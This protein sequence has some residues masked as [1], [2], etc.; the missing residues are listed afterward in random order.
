VTDSEKHSSLLR[1]G[2]CYCCKKILSK[3]QRF[4]IQKALLH[5]RRKLNH[6]KKLFA[7]YAKSSEASLGNSEWQNQ[8]TLTELEGSVHLTSSLS[9][10]FGKKKLKYTISKAANLN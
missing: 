9:C 3:S 6:N 4:F 7:N 1:Y 10:F 8:G 2:S 5:Q